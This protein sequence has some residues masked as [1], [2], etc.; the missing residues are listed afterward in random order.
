MQSILFCS[1]RG[2]LTLEALVSLLIFMFLMLFMFGLFFMSMAQGATAHAVLQS[3]HSLSV[4]VFAV[5]KLSGKTWTDGISALL[6]TLAAT[7]S[8]SSAKNP[9]YVTDTKWYEGAKVD[10]NIIKLRFIGYLTGGNKDAADFFLK[11]V[12]VVNG[13][14]GLDFSESKIVNGDLYITL[15]YKVEFV[16]RIPGAMT[17][18]VSQTAVSRLWK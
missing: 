13:L 6:G 11:M 2:A 5:E 18:D 15:N 17:L 14:D 10:E 1:E 8:G 7:L 12:R 3:S 4:D 16:F 9:N